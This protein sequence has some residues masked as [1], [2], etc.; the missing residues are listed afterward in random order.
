MKISGTE[1]ALVGEP[2][3][4]YMSLLKNGISKILISFSSSLRL[5]KAFNYELDKRSF[6]KKTISFETSK[7]MFDNN[8]TL[9]FVSK[10]PGSGE[11]NASIHIKALDIEENVK[12]MSVFDIEILKP[13]IH[14]D[15]T[16]ENE[17]EN[18]NIKLEKKISE[19]TTFFKGLKVSAKDY[20]TKKDVKVEIIRFSEEEYV[21]NLENIPIIFD[22]DSAIKEIVIHSN[23]TVELN[24]HACYYDLLNNEYESNKAIIVL[25]LIVEKYKE[26]EFITTPIFNAIGFESPGIAMASS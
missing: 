15:I 4:L 24:M 9:E 20:I 26:E 17:P 13:E 18:L 8:L 7:F 25:Q 22:I 11:F 10:K 23:S 16:Q 3:V 5:T 21:E 6:F 2:I 14:I 1:R 12:E 19:I